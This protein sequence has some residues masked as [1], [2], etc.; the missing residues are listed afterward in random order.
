[1]EY[2]NFLSGVVITLES[3]VLR[4]EE[5]TESTV[6]GNTAG[7]ATRTSGIGLAGGDGELG[8]P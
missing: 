4:S 1:M 2:C 6:A 5:S 7:I 8:W 3:N